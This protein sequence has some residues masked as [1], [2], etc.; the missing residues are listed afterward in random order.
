MRT[1]GDVATVQ[2]KI[3]RMLGDRAICMMFLW[4]T[5]ALLLFL[6]AYPFLML[7][8]NSFFRYSVLRPAV[9]PEF[10]G[11]S[12]Y[13]FFL[14]DDYTWARFIF[15]GKF[16][17]LAVLIQFVLGICIAYLLQTKFKGRDVIFTMLLMPMMLCPIIVGLFWRYLFNSEWG[18]INYLISVV[19][20]IQL[21]WLGDPTYSLWAVVI[22]D[23]WMWTPFTILLATAAFSG[24]PKALYEAADVD[25]ASA[26]FKFFNITLPMSAPVLVIA[27]LLRLIDSFKQF[28]LFYA[29]TGGGPGDATQTASFMLYKTAFQYFYT[30]EAS[31][32]GMMLL[33]I[34]I[35]LSSVFIRY[36]ST[37]SERQKG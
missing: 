3:P 27:L 22:A 29:L 19:A 20:N 18:L 4:P 15:T 2:S 32:L 35:G 14:S 17:F 6:I 21:E 8:Y 36:L 31:A 12:N 7:I 37:L 28:D 11:F 10:I 16:V 13:L 1:T 30:G 34:I 24:I 26:G 33:I 25:G 9:E 5:L 23:T